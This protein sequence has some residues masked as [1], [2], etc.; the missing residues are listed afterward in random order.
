MILKAIRRRPRLF[1]CTVLTALLLASLIAAVQPPRFVSS[2]EVVLDPA[3]LTGDPEAE[4]TEASA[5]LH[6]PEA[7]RAVSQSLERTSA[8]R[9]LGRDSGWLSIT[10]ERASAPSRTTNP[11]AAETLLARRFAAHL[12][13]TRIPQSYALEIGFSGSDARA[14]AAVANAF[15]AQLVQRP[16]SGD[17]RA[18]PMR[19]VSAAEESTVRR[20]PAVWLIL[21][22]GALLGSAIGMIVVILAE[23]R[24]GGLT[25]GSDITDQLALYH[26]GSVP[27][28]RSVLPD[29]AS[30]VDAL[31]E[32]PF[33]GYAEAF[34]AILVAMQQIAPT[35]ARVFAVTSAL[36]GEGKSTT[37][38]CLARSAAQT[39]QRVVIVDCDCRRA[40]T[41]AALVSESKGPGIAALLRGACDLDQ[42]LVQDAASGAWVLPATPGEEDL[43]VGF[44]SEAFEALIG[45][46]RTRFD[47]IIIDT[48]PILAMAL[49]RAILSLADGVIMVVRWR[50]TPAEAVKAAVAMVPTASIPRTGVALVQVDMRKQARYGGGDAST[51]YQQSAAY[52]R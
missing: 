41:S 26:L 52:Y 27:L 50:E 46:L 10:R 38:A 49:T 43:S 51:Y 48:P 28:L 22:M 2:A 1:G 19:F 8:R 36:P 40:G 14:T 45:Q 7:A 17:R 31:I 32:A 20:G 23:R 3:L 37:A 29:A 42:V 39:G 18:M 6:S 16:R 11:A 24:L 15:A 13:V 5:W 44:A 47:H 4:L 12:L 25:S 34:R 33:S 30:P 9:L 21:S 35:D